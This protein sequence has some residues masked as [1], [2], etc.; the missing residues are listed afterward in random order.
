MN[1][2]NDKKRGKAKLNILFLALIFLGIIYFFG[3]RDYSYNIF[4]STINSI[5]MMMNN[6]FIDRV[7]YKREHNPV[8]L[9]GSELIL[10]GSHGNVDEDYAV[11][12]IYLLNSS[13]LWVVV[14]QS[15]IVS[16]DAK[17]IQNLFINT[18]T[19]FKELTLKNNS[20]QLTQLQNDFQLHSHLFSN[21]NKVAFNQLLDFKI[22]GRLRKCDK[23]EIDGAVNLLNRLNQNS[24]L[25]DYCLVQR[26]PIWKTSDF[27][28]T[29]AILLIFLILLYFFFKNLRL[30][31]KSEK[32]N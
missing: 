12:L 30:L 15:A 7:D 20:N 1:V 9:I 16:S 29:I 10:A 8:T 31:F 2:N 14:Y 24:Q 21:N 17:I 25:S 28:M 32:S 27:G 26:L 6:G 19:L 18:N 13:D 11:N 3:I 5:G 22:T 23:D 4:G